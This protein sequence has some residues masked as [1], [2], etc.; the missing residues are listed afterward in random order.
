MKICIIPAR[1]GSKRILRKNIKEF[2][3]KPII[4]YS[5]EAALNS[6]LFSEVM[7]STE[8][9]EIAEIS[10]YYGAEVPFMRPDH[11]ADDFASTPDVMEHAATWLNSIEDKPSFICCI[12]ATAPLIDSHYLKAGLQKILHGQ[13][14][15]AISAVS[16]P[17]PIQRA[18][19]ITDDERI[20]MFFPENFHKRSQDLEAVYHDAGQFYWGKTQA[21]LTKKLLFSHETA[22][23][24]LPM[25]QVQDIDT[26]EDWDIAE[27]KCKILHHD[28]K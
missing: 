23:V 22:P 7:V 12:A 13:C 26:L 2:N 25:I 24:L 15:Y 28:N 17:S 5:I 16:Y 10:R 14:D 19:R 6:G 27:L 18:F 9:D 3:G 4:A 11:L 20:E 8:D 1:G 21:W